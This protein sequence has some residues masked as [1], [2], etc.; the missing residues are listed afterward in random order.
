ML[1]EDF[2]MFLTAEFIPC[3]IDGF[4]SRMKSKSIAY[5]LIGS[6]NIYWILDLEG[7]MHSKWD[8]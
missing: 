1:N 7:E 4:T 2:V 6:E 5:L 8:F 3:F